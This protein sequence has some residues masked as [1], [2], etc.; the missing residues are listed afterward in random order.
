[1]LATP[2]GGIPDVIKDGKTGFMLQ[3][4]SP[5]C[6]AMNV[7]KILEHPNLDRISENARE[8]IEQEYTYQTVVKRYQQILQVS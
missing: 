7:I 5:E 6:I 8:L 2:V 1:V 3:D 4:N